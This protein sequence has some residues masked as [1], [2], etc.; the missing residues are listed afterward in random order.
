MRF[1]AALALTALTAFAGS[2][3]A[4]EP[5]PK[6]LVSFPQE[7]TDIFAWMRGN[8]WKSKR[9]DPGRF[10]IE[11][12]ALHMVS[13]NDSVLLAT[14]RGFPVDPRLRPKLRMTFR[15]GKIPAGA[16]LS[17]KNGDDSAFRVYVAFE[18]GGGIFSPPHTI[19]YTWT[20]N[21]ASGRAVQSAHFKNLRYLSIG[22]GIPAAP[23]WITIERDLLEDY[24]RLFPK[25]ADDVPLLRGIAL[26]CDTNNTGGS[27]E[28]WLSKIELLPR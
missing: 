25:H 13:D 16:D 12:G 22:S 14:E 23:D 20:E 24:R 9:N 26:K 7:K 28:S 27:A 15:V 17:R 19:A 6:P 21:L 5:R 8:Q 3:T 1:A 18:R 2:P 4:R 11:D 10:I